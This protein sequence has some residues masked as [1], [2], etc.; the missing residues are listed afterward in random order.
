MSI[1]KENKQYPTVA[2]NHLITLCEVFEDYEAFYNDLEELI[3]PNKKKKVYEH[4][5]QKKVYDYIMQEN[6]YINNEK[7]DAFIEKHKHTIEVMKKYCCLSDFMLWYFDSK[8]ER[9]NDF[10][11]L[12]DY[13]LEYIEKHKK[14]ID[15]MK[16]LVLKIKELG[17]EVITFGEHLDFTKQSYSL[18]IPLLS[19]SYDCEFEFLENMECTPTYPSSNNTTR[20][21]TSS[22]HYLMHLTL[23]NPESQG[24]RSNCVRN[25]EL[26]SL[27]FS[28]SFLPNEITAETTINVIKNLIEKNKAESKDIKDTVDL[29]IA[30]DRLKNE[31][32][33]LKKRYETIDKVKENQELKELLIGMQNIMAK[34][35]IFE[36][37]F[38]KQIIDTY[39]NLSEDIIKK[40]KKQEDDR[41]KDKENFAE[42]IYFCC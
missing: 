35:Q 11:L 41:K 28:P 6:I 33:S 34:L 24:I 9:E 1:N 37:S 30:T 4:I 25:I 26:N 38:S 16:Q 31:F 8:G 12:D 40:E 2:T 7:I 39:P 27:V 5:S 18:S 22:S 32:E 20:Y 10:F 17:I 13:I 23:Y 3:K 42:H 14:D 29:S 21:K 19:T 36:E 15:T